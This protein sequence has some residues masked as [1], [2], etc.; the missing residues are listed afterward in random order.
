M[1]VKKNIVCDKK[2]RERIIQVEHIRNKK[3]FDELL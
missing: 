3:K 1:E 2:E